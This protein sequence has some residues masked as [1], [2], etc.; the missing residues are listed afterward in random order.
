MPEAGPAGRAGLDPALP[1]GAMEG[2]ELSTS[3]GHHG[4]GPVGRLS[5]G[6]NHDA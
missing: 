3:D 2:G 4:S 5:T 6:A 1:A